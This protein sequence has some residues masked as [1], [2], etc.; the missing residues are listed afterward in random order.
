MVTR[1]PLMG[2]LIWVSRQPVD[3]RHLLLRTPSRPWEVTHLDNERMEM[4]SLTQLALALSYCSPPNP[5]VKKFWL[6]TI[7][8]KC[9]SYSVLSVR[10]KSQIIWLA[11][12]I[13]FDG[14]VRGGGLKREVRIIGST[15]ICFNGGV[16]YFSR[17][18][19]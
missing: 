8:C 17:P 2:T 7:H 9:L 10:L 11:L 4:M 6:Y 14:P 3:S 16:D 18:R 13:L 12:Y 19:W 15:K 1:G 5:S